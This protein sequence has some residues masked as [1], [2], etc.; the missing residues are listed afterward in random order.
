MLNMVCIKSSD[1]MITMYYPNYSPIDCVKSFSVMCECALTLASLE[2]AECVTLHILQ[3]QSGFVHTRESSFLLSFIQT[4][5]T[6]AHHI[7][8]DRT[9][10]HRQKCGQ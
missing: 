7:T 5:S 9:G 2:S 3:S 10:Q 1:R 6:Y 4:T 8:L